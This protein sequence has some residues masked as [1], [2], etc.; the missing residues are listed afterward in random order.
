MKRFFSLM[1]ILCLCGHVLIAQSQIRHKFSFNPDQLKTESR[2]KESFNFQKLKMPDFLHTTDEVGKP[3]MPVKQINLLLPPGM[4]ANK[5]NVE[6]TSKRK[7]KLT[8]PVYPAQPKIPTSMESLTKDT[9]VAIIICHT[10]PLLVEVLQF[11]IQWIL[12]MV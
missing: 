3:E 9:F 2:Q 12:K 4:E 10:K 5:V 1:G 8:S 6:I 7:M 11:L